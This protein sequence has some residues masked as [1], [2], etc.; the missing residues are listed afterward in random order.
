MIRDRV[1]T[2]RI[3]SSSYQS[4]L[5]GR[6]PGTVTRFNR[7]LERSSNDDGDRYGKIAAQFNSPSASE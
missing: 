1:Y 6:G 7:H 4:G 3:G 5:G 2:G